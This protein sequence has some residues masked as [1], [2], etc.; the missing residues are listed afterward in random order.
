MKRIYQP[1]RREMMQALGGA[2]GAA[3]VGCGGDNL[4]TS[5]EDLLGGLLGDW[6]TEKPSTYGGPLA[7][8]DNIVV[9]VMEN[10][11]FDHTF[12]SL[13]IPTELGGEGQRGIRGLGLDPNFDGLNAW[14]HG[15]DGMEYNL[16][17]DGNKVHAFHIADTTAP[18]EIVH[19]WDDCWRQFNYAL[20]PNNPF[21]EGKNDGFLRHHQDD[22]KKPEPGCMAVYFD[23]DGRCA[24][25]NDP[26]G[27][28]TRA[29]LPVLYE[30]ATQYTLCDNWHASVL[31]PTWPN[32]YYMHGAW[33]A[34]VTTNKP[35][36]GQ[37]YR[38]IWGQLVD[39]C[40]PR[41]NYYFDIPW[42][43]VFRARL[44]DMARVYKAQEGSG[45]PSQGFQGAEA[46]E[47]W[48]QWF[49]RQFLRG[50]ELINPSMERDI[51]EGTM[52]GF[53]I[54]DPGF[55]F[56]NDDH[57]PNDVVMGQALIAQLYT[58]LSKNRELWNRTLFIITYDEHG[59][60]FDHVVPGRVYD[61]SGASG[62]DQLGIRVPAVVCGG[63]VKRGHVSKVQYD[64]CSVIKT[65]TK[66]WDLEYINDRVLRD[67]E[68]GGT[69]A[70]E[71]C[72][73]T[74]YTDELLAKLPIPTVPQVSIS[75]S[76]AYDNLHK[77][78]TQS[79]LEHWT[80]RGL[81][82]ASHDRRK[83]ARLDMATFLRVGEELGVVK[84]TR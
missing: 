2:A 54:I 73:D 27:Y 49:E 31:G 63:R 81:I 6:C 68:E 46:D 1:T 11:S 83:L 23:N 59:S 84:V 19:D 13:S 26:M 12:G 3:M 78:A 65:A 41:R 58:M 5:E 76:K 9:L 47:S 37:G 79:E 28:Y 22:L 35:I 51:E 33:S 30:L 82:P 36:L 16:D 29:Q 71:D 56:G 17:V 64:H 62:F 32:R 24:R 44:A 55:K 48:S 77:G 14:D 60:F 72:I 38:T 18:G 4:G 57:P 80:D 50:S 45:L 7:G 61:R 40:I 10:R 69:A 67:V 43:L 39:K 52:R 15:P 8:I 53:H 42:A 74:A 20:G 75:E 21:R 34:G 70:L 66:I 25:K